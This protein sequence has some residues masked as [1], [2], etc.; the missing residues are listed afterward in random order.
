MKYYRLFKD[1]FIDTNPIPVKAAM[2][3]MGLIE[4]VYRLPLCGMNKP[5]HTI[6]RQILQ[7]LEL[8]GPEIHD[9]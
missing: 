4:E 3:M 1:L 9:D 6:L 8:I 5:N 2:A 7:G